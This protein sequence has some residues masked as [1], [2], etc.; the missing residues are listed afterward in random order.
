MRFTSI[1]VILFIPSPVLNLHSDFL[2]MQKYHF[3]VCILHAFGMDEE[4]CCVAPCDRCCE[5]RCAQCV[6]PNQVI[7]ARA[8]QAITSMVCLCMQLLG[9]WDLLHSPEVSHVIAS[10]FH[11]PPWKKHLLGG[12]NFLS[13]SLVTG[14]VASWGH[15]EHSQY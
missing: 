9:E 13:S 2:P 6:C 5:Q 1:A 4:F 10:L 12:Y 15:L 3:L 14:P 11:S 8:L 7:P